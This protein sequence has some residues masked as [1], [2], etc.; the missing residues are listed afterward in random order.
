MVL[1]NRFPVM[2]PAVVEAGR[3]WNFLKTTRGQD[4]VEDACFNG[5]NHQTKA[6]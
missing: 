6:S 5:K 3:V 1:Y 2:Y 4:D